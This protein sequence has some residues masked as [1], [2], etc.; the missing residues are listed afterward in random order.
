MLSDGD[1]G[2]LFC[3]WRRRG[4]IIVHPPSP[5]FVTGNGEQ[6]PGDY[7]GGGDGGGQAVSVNPSASGDNSRRPSTKTSWHGMWRG[8]GG[9]VGGGS[10]VA[11]T[12]AGHRQ[13]EQAWWRVDVAAAAS[14]GVSAEKHQRATA[15]ARGVAW[16]QAAA[17]IS[18]WRRAN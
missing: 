9:V 16:R 14:G 2:D 6:L 1:S 17:S 3:S 10:V 12:I 11:A 18:W 15:A 7:C 4:G 13:R 8:G 5:L